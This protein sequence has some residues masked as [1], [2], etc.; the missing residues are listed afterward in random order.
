LQ[1]A[2]VIEQKEEAKFLRI[3]TPVS[4]GDASAG[5]TAYPAADGRFSITYTI[6]YPESSAARHTVHFNASPEAFLKEISP[7][8]TFALKAHAEIMTAKGFGKGATRDNTILLDGDKP[9]SVLRFPDECA[10]H[11]ILDLIGDLASIGK[12]I[13]AHITAYRSGHKLNLQLAQALLSSGWRA[14]FPKGIM[15]I[16]KIEKTIPHRYPFLLVDRVLELEPGE[17]IVALKNVTR[18]EEF[19]EGHFP[20]QPIMP[21]VLQI[22]AIAQ[23]GALMFLGNPEMEGKLAVLARVDEVKYKRPVV[24]GDQ[25]I[26]ESIME[27]FSPKLGIG[28]AKARSTVDGE[29]ATECKITFALVDPEHYG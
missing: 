23:A 4:V 20:G 10:R 26:M 18:N 21:G 19:F 29:T 11:K 1:S 9:E 15:D 16:R 8:R 7:A 28:T 22:E 5:I 24:P 14:D 17:R 2:G 25:I 12:R 13:S 6:D 27:R 3:K